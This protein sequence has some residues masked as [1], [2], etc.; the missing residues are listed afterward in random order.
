MCSIS[1]LLNNNFDIYILYKNINH[2]LVYRFLVLLVFIISTSFCSP[3]SEIQTLDELT[4]KADFIVY[5]NDKYVVGDTIWG[6]KNYVY[7]VVGHQESPLLLGV[8]HDGLEHG[9]PEIPETGNTGRDINTHKLAQEI[10]HH[11]EKRSKFKAWMI[12]NKIHRKRVDP[13]TYPNDLENRYTSSEA[14]ETYKSYHDLLRFARET[15]AS[16]QKT[17]GNGGLFLDMH[18]HAHKYVK[19]YEGEYRSVLSGEFLRSSFISQSELGY[20]LSKYALQQNDEYLNNLADSSSV[21]YL[22]KRHPAV[23]F[24]EIIRGENSFGALLEKEGV[25]AVPSNKIKKLAYNAELFGKDAKGNAKLR[26][27]FTGGYCTRQ[28]GTVQKGNVIGYDDSIIS[29][30]IETPGINI[31]NNDRLIKESSKQ[32]NNALINYLNFW[33]NYSF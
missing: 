30:Q 11:F 9:S 21:Y 5:K 25:V 28:Y 1:T 19:G 16:Y 23:S 31:R 7:L 12:V 15:M 33:M 32:I 6:Y 20:A 26:P 18:G 27:Y 29:I 8:P 3:A 13:N 2:M 22:A 17:A 10:A 24:S 14:L 4:Q